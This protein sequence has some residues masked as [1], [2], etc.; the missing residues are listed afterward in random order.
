MIRLA[1]DT[2]TMTQS[3]AL[4][5]DG[6]VVAHRSVTRRTGHSTSLLRS[7]EGVLEDAEVGVSDVDVVLCGLGPGS[8]T[9]VRVGLSLALGLCAGTGARLGGVSSF[10]ALVP[11]VPPQTLCAVALDAR[12]GEVYAG[13]WE[14][15][16]SWT[17]RIEPQTFDPTTFFET[18]DEHPERERIVLIGDGARAYAQAFSPFE[19]RIRVIEALHTPHAAQL[20]SAADHGLVRWRDEGI[21]EPLY[22]RPSD[23]ELNPKF[24]PRQAP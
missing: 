2:A 1:I 10:Y 6:A 20:F 23:A 22:I 15:A 21:L 11:L 4:E 3:V 18:L 14:A 12:K 8:F 16:P 17:A 19:G 7:L 13:V 5:R 24:S 9:G